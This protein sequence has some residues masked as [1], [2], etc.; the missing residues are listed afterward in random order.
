MLQG[1]LLAGGDSSRMGRQKARL[2]I[3]GEE[4]WLHLGR[5]MLQAGCSRVSI[6][7]PATLQ[8]PLSGLVPQGS[9]LRLVVVPEDLRQQGAIG[10]LSH[11]ITETRDEYEACLVAPV[12][13]PYVSVPTLRRL[14]VEVGPIR[15]PTFEGRR[16]HPIVL[17]AEIARRVTHLKG[18][19]KT[20]CRDP[21][22][23]TNEIPVMDEA[24]L[25]NLD[26]PEDYEQFEGKKG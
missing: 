18:T 25:W 8:E 15:I 23:A 4:A 7:I 5:M 14:M 13:H 26:R 6:A 10:S 24:I 21:E 19:L 22:I 12:D 16:G 20:L 3:Q 2:E 11:L 9:P 17:E 1:F